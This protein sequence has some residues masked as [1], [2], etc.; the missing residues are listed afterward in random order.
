M[1]F[2]KSLVCRC[3]KAAEAAGY[4]LFGVQFYGE[5]WSADNAE[6]TFNKDGPSSNCISDIGVAP[7]PCTAGSSDSCVGQQFTNYVYQLREG[8]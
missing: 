1:V 4:K 7:P 2:P 5:C 3:A 6:A 8:R